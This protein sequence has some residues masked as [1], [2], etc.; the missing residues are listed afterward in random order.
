MAFAVVDVDDGDDD[1]EKG[2]LRWTV[3]G[4]LLFF[5][6]APMENLKLHRKEKKK[7]VK[8]VGDY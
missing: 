7:K 6:P 4:L 5:F 1:A 2:V 3:I 8:T